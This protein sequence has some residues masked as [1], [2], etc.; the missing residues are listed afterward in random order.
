MK[1]F[2]LSLLLCSLW[3]ISGWAQYSNVSEYLPMEDFRRI[4]KQQKV[5]SVSRIW[6]DGSY[7]K[8]PERHFFNEKG[9]LTA[10]YTSVSM[11]GVYTYEHDS[12]GR[13]IKSYHFNYPKTEQYD[14]YTI[15]K[16]DSLGN[17]IR[18]DRYRADGERFFFSESIQRSEGAYYYFTRIENGKDS[19]VIRLR[20]DSLQQVHYT[21]YFRY[22]DGTLIGADT[23][24][25]YHN[26]DG[27]ATRGG[28][29]DY[30]DAL[31]AWL[32]EHPEDQQKLYTSIAYRYELVD[33]GKLDASL[34]NYSENE[35]YAYLEDG[36]TKEAKDYL[37]IK[38]YEYNEDGFPIKITKFS[39]DRRLKSVVEITYGEN[40]LIRQ[41]VTTRADGT[42]ETPIV[43]EY[44]FWE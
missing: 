28:E 23:N 8:Y 19:S 13:V 27:A 37:G 40:K 10:W 21:D 34:F 7:Q 32:E 38:E 24:Y 25:E 2:F 26:K 33:A 30:N 41:E 1:Q 14:S 39:D 5:K 12:I 20:Y 31:G 11:N 15:R 3:H 44:E 17:P 4:A 35:R 22:E 43:Y 9:Y 42:T 16:L 18:V 29:L 36:S 6:G